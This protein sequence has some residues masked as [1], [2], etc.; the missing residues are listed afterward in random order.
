MRDVYTK[1]ALT[2]VGVVCPDCPASVGLFFSLAPR[3]RR[4]N[5]A[6]RLLAWQPQRP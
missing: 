3:M 2:P 5:W 4:L 6:R 1:A